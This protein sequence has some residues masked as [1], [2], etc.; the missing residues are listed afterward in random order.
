MEDTKDSSREDGEFWYCYRDLLR[1]LKEL[2]ECLPD[3]NETTF[4]TLPK[5]LAIDDVLKNVPSRLKSRLLPILE[6]ELALS[7]LLK[8]KSRVD[9][10]VIVRDMGEEAQSLWFTRLNK[11]N[12]TEIEEDVEVLQAELE[13]LQAFEV[14]GDVEN[15]NSSLE[16]IRVC[17]QKEPV[18]E[19]LGLLNRA[20]MEDQGG[21]EA[22]DLDTTDSA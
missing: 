5:K 15:E 16:M 18:Q 20:T 17:L 3:P 11:M 7:Y 10:T 9:A 22:G 2:E 1:I 6:P 14:D 4:F 8:S 13:A 19:L 12:N 21:S